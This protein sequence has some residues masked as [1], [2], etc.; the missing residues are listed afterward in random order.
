MKNKGFTIIELGISFCIVSAISIV[1]FQLVISIKDLYLAGNIKTTLLNKQGIITKRIHDDIEAYDLKTVNS[2]GL[3]CLEFT[4]TD[5]DDE[6]KTKQAKLLLDPYNM[7]ITYDDY[8]IELENGSSFGNIIVSYDKVVDE[9]IKNTNNRILQIKIP[10][11]NKLVDGDFGL[12]IVIQYNDEQTTVNNQININ[13]VYLTLGGIDVKIKD[14][15]ETENGNNIKQGT[16]ARIFYHNIGNGNNL[17]TS[18]NEFIKSNTDT[19]FSV[20]FALKVFKLTPNSANDK[21]YEFLLYY[22]SSSVGTNYNRWIQS[23]NF[24]KEKLSGYE[25]IDIVWNAGGDWNG[26]DYADNDCTYVDGLA[27]TNDACYFSIGAKKAINGNLTFKSNI[28][29]TSQDVELWVKI[30]E[31]INRYSLSEVVH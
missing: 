21:A 12:N 1:L 30:D 10:I 3:S 15:Y 24:I 9:S 4:Y 18:K 5:K 28:E 14:L 25:P 6:T 22:P 2:C 11:N 8:S 7:T 29:Y 23:S 19:K 26:L 31:Y 27:T 20:L 16:Y 17:F 13:D